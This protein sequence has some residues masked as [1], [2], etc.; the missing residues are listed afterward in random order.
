MFCKALV[1][2]ENVISMFG[3]KKYDFNVL[4]E[5]MILRFWRENMILRFWRKI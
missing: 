4:V 5:N 2:T 1:L 3:R